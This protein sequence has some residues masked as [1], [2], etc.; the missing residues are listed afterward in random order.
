MSKENSG[1]WT[2]VARWLHWGM[3]LAILIEVPAGYLMA[4]TYA[5]PGAE[6]EALHITAS[7]T[8]HTLG[9]L[10]LAAVLFRLGW[11]FTHPAPPMPSGAGWLEKALAR[12]VQLLLYALLVAIPLTGWA[13]LSSLAEFGNYGPT[14]MWFFTHDGFGPDGIFPRLV[15]AVAYDSGELLSYSL[16]GSAHVWLIYLGGCLLLLHILAALRHHFVS[17][18]NVLRQMM[19]RADD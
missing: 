11:R 3:A 6:N 14:R 5:P 2:R 8:H 4:Y 12:L 7:Q 9:M 15:P 17:R 16:F 19:G 1:G 13:A 10:I 18:N